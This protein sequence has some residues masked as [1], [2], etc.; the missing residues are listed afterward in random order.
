VP[1][2][3][4]LMSGPFGKALLVAEVVTLVGCGAVYYQLTTNDRWV[5]AVLASERAFGATVLLP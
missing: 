2:Y 4:R 1:K 5:T 3:Q